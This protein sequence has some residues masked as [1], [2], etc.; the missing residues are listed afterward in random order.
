[1]Q[2]TRGRAA[3]ACEIVSVG[4]PELAATAVLPGIGPSARSIQ[5]LL[6]AG[7]TSRCQRK[8]VGAAAAPT[9]NEAFPSEHAYPD[10]G[11]E[12]MT[13]APQSTDTLRLSIAQDSSSSGW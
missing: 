7:A 8:E 1:M 5:V 3:S 13:G 11:W 10:A 4:V 12:R 2:Q 6:P 9:V